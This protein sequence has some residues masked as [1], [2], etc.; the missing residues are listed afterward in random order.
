MPR[1]ERGERPA[2]GRREQRVL[3]RDDIKGLLAA[4]RANA[5]P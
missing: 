2:V 3:A 1:L 5:P 4:A